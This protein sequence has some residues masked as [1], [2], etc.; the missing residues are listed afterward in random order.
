MNYWSDYMDFFLIKYK[1]VSIKKYKYKYMFYWFWNNKGS[2]G[3]FKHLFN[4][5]WFYFHPMLNNA[6][7]KQNKKFILVC[8]KGL[9]FFLIE[10][11]K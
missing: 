7:T 4:L 5:Q 10:I 8:K 2:S 9:L 6:K 1:S 11:S 3:I